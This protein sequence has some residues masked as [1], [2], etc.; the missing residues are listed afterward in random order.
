MIALSVPEKDV[1]VVFD[2][3]DLDNNGVLDADEFM[4]VRTCAVQ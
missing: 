4:Q 1:E 3:M 2:V